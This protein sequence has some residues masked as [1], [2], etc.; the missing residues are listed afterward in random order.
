M[1]SCMK[2]K[3]P[4]FSAE[5]VAIIRAVESRRKEKNR[6][7]YD[8]YAERLIRFSFG[9]LLKSKLIMKFICMYIEKHGPGFQGG[10]TARTCYIDDLLQSCIDDGI[11][12]LV[13]LGA[14]CDARAYR[15]NSLK[16]IRVFEV[17]FPATQNYKISKL[18]KIF[19][20]LPGHVKYVPV[21][22][23]SETTGECLLEAGF[24]VN[25]KTFYIWEGVTMYLA[26]EAVDET[27]SFVKNNSGPGS[28]IHF[29]YMLKSVLDGTCMLP[30]SRKIRESGSFRGNGEEAFV[31]GLDEKNIPGFLEERGMTLIEN[32]KGAQ[33]KR[34][35]KIRRKVHELFGYV[36]ATIG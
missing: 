20:S 4:S 27:L 33:L 19:G 32:I 3:K 29:D 11:K 8:P 18:K 21:D 10:I 9:I 31:F 2:E 28:S 1:R 26:P 23:N 16:N 6:I 17:D 24:D 34:R 7:V 35:Y 25:K 36:Y 12:Q 13:I 30:E 5:I 22:F 15:I 14:G